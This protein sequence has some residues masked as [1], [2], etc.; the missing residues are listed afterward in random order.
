MKEY[1]KE[2]WM[3]MELPSSLLYSHRDRNSEGRGLFSIKEFTGMC[4]RAV[5]SVTIDI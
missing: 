4:E 1:D 5:I 2:K 3:A